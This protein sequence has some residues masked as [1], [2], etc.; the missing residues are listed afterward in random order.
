MENDFRFLILSLRYNGNRIV[1]IGYRN[2]E[3]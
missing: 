1:S 3:I 2:D